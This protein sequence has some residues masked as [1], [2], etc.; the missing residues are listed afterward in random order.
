MDTPKSK[1]GEKA[2]SGI[3]QSVARGVERMEVDMAELDAILGR[4]SKGPL[5]E[6]D[7][8]KLRASLDTLGFI[9]QEL[10]KKKVSVE[11]L[12]E[13][14]FGPSTEKTDKVIEKVKKALAL[15]N[16]ESSSGDGAGSEKKKKKG[17]GRNGA[18]S[19]TGARKVIVPLE[20]LSAGCACPSCAKGKLYA[21]VDPKRIVRV[22]GSA[23]LPP[24]CTSWGN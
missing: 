21:S 15:Q 14:L 20:G 23:R 1:N 6:E 5:D 16:G 9:T 22:R 4:A 17:H 13:L 7:L 3:I 12:K 18:R 11:R 19:Y 24:P 2:E 8:E 10:A